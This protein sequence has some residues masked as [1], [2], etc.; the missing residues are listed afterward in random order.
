MSVGVGKDSNTANHA[1]LRC[2]SAKM[3]F[4]SRVNSCFP[5]KKEKKI[6]NSTKISTEMLKKNT[7]MPNNCVR[8]KNKDRSIKKKEALEHCAKHTLH[9]MHNQVQAV[10]H[11]HAYQMLVK[12]LNRR[13]CVFFSFW[14]YFILLKIVWKHK[15]SVCSFL[16]KHSSRRSVA[17]SK[18]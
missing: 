1:K 2:L 5:K 12:V 4:I 11:L 16:M 7:S 17:L 18:G 9:N 10:S 6:L 13:I 8:N 15:C 14:F 3:R